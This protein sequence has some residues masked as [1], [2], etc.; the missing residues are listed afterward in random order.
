MSFWA[1]NKQQRFLEA[2]IN[3]SFCSERSDSHSL[4]TSSIKK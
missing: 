2:L 3:F 4:K 1:E